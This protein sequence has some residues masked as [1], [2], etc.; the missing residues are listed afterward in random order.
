[1]LGP[2]L[3]KRATAWLLEHEPHVSAFATLSPIPKFAPWLQLQ[4]GG[5]GGLIG[6]GGAG[7]TSAPD[8]AVCAGVAQFALREREGSTERPL[9]PPGT[10]GLE[11]APWLEE[12]AGGDG[13][14]R[15]SAADRALQ[16]ALRLPQWKEREDV[17]ALVRP[18]LVRLCAQYLLAEKNRSRSL[19][20]VANFHL[21]NGAV[22]VAESGGGG[23][24][25]ERRLTHCARCRR[26]CTGSIGWATRRRRCA[27]SRG[28]T[29]RPRLTLCARAT[30]AQGMEQS[31]G[32]MVNY[33]Y[34]LPNLTA[35]STVR[36]A[37]PSCVDELAGESKSR[38][39][40]PPPLPVAQQYTLEGAIVTGGP[41]RSLLG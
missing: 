8:P 31:Y 41:V 20:P 9:V 25:G 38:S 27:A 16:S 11:D 3:I 26:S 10:S 40:C 29:R 12:Q 18:A 5:C 22:R 14:G 39:C 35:N 15:L 23:G 1:M 33:R 37:P 19:C 13:G 36:G 32:L 34:D 28:P 24:G 17:V 4:V 7:A 30:A 6:A 2:N 21:G